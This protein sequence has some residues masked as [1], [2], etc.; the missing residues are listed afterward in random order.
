MIQHS[1]ILAPSALARRH[2]LRTALL[3][4]ALLAA[5]RAHALSLADLTQKDVA[6]G[7]KTALERGADIAVDLLG[8]T[9]GFW[10]NDKVRIPLPEWLRRGERALK[11]LGYGND[12][13]ELRLGVNRAAEQ[14]VPESRTLLANA[15]K[16]MSVADAKQIVGGGD[17]AITRFFADKTR[18]PLTTR[19]LPIVAK[20][21]SNIGLAQQYNGLAAQGAKL[22][23][24]KGDQVRVE[25]HVTAKALDGL[26][27]MIG[28]EEK[29]IRRD[30]IATGSEILRRVFGTR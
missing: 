7:L 17:T 10:S 21:T 19:F 18:S 24:V 8:K 20:T 26:Y 2:A 22:G 27:F 25:R 9:D 1:L 28:E 4:A 5:R 11:L 13:D 15:V 29:K 16:S 14:A 3:M 6:A 23:L 30:P 12:I